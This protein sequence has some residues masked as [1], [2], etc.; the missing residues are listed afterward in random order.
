MYHLGTSAFY[1][2]MLLSVSFADIYFLRYVLAR[3]LNIHFLDYDVLRIV[4]DE[5][6]ID[7]DTCSRI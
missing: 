7:F 3:I 5:N 4:I 2:M 6:A 1:I